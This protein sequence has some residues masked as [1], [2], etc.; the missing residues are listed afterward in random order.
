MKKIIISLCMLLSFA[1][2]MDAGTK[3]LS[4]SGSL[5]DLTG[6]AMT[7]DITTG[8]GYFMMDNMEVTVGL[9]LGGT[10]DDMTM[11]YMLGGNY[12]M[13]S[14]YGGAKYSGGDAYADGMLDFRAGYLCALGE[15]GS[16]YLNLY[17]NYG[18][19]LA[20]GAEG[21][22]SLGFGIVTFF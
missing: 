15:G 22:L 11:D 5:N 8:V 4:G 9:G 20:E 21:A 13:G 16:A 17:G 18:M 12:Y 2:A 3:S 10:T 1:L 14:M 19:S 6:D 7:L